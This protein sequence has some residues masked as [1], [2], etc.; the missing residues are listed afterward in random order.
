MNTIND[1][2]YE[3][4][5]VLIGID[6]NLP[7]TKD[8]NPKVTDATRIEKSKNTILT[9]SEKGAKVVLLTHLGRPK[10]EVANG[11]SLKHAIDTA[12]EILGKEIKFVGDCVGEEVK[13]AIDSLENGEIL[14]LEN[15]RF[16]IEETAYKKKSDEENVKAFA[17]ELGSYYDE[18]VEDGLHLTARNSKQTVVLNSKHECYCR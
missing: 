6:W 13:N 11:L 10:G 15:V 7:L 14:L 8:E 17:K 18:F 16:H 3:G 5:K 1:K 9:L 12:K 4:K 2:D